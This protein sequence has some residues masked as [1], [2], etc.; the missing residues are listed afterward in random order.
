MTFIYDGWCMS[1]VTSVRENFS[2]VNDF[3]S[4]AE[5][6]RLHV[7]RMRKLRSVLNAFPCDVAC[8]RPFVH[9]TFLM[10]FACESHVRGYSSHMNLKF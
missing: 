4:H 6:G 3:F 1:H 7:V 2:H 10:R 9:L 8:E 5:N